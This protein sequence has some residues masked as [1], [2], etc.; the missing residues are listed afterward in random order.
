[1]KP[2]RLTLLALAISAA[3]CGAACLAA[4]YATPPNEQGMPVATVIA[5]WELTSPQMFRMRRLKSLMSDSS[6]A[7]S[8][9]MPAGTGPAPVPASPGVQASAARYIL[10]RPMSLMY[11]TPHLIVTQA[12]VAPIARETPG[13]VP[14]HLSLA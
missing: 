1:M 4:R 8:S 10:A 2:I 9:P 7:S 13:A 11:V 14:Y 12:R 3:A 6:I 5:I